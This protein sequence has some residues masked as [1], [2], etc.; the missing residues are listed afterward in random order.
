MVGSIIAVVGYLAST[1]IPVMYSP[2][3]ISDFSISVD[4][5]S[6]IVL[7]DYENG[8]DDS[9]PLS[10]RNTAFYL[11][12]IP[13]IV[14]GRISLFLP[15]FSIDALFQAAAVLLWNW[16]TVS[17]LL[18]ARGRSGSR[19]LRGGRVRLH[20]PGPAHAHASSRAAAVFFE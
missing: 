8:A 15:G 1:M 10:K 18:H 19:I 12:V 11:P 3:D 9:D 14:A 6:S 17:I 7:P 13:Y 20:P 16:Q 4:P 5:V 2:A